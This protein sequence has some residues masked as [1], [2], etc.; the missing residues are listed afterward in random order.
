MASIESANLDAFRTLMASRRPTLI[1]LSSN[2][3]SAP[4]RALAAQYRTASAPYCSRSGMGVTTFPFDFDI[5]VRSGSRTHP[6]MAALVHGSESC[7]RCDF[8]TV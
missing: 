8:S 1:W 2:A 4:R 6:E 5:F 7:S 3:V